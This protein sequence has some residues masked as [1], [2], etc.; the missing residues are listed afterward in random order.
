[1]A[2]RTDPDLDHL[3]F[4]EDADPG[5]PSSPIA[6]PESGIPPLVPSVFSEPWSVEFGA[7]SPASVTLP[8]PMR[9]Q[10]DMV[11]RAL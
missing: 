6:T 10:L 11:S 3:L 8:A 7:A 2:V 5:L 4:D 1:M 9:I